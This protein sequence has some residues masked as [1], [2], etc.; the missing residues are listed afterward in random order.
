MK[1]KHT[2]KAAFP[3]KFISVFAKKFKMHNG[4]YECTFGYEAGKTAGLSA[5]GAFGS[6]EAG[7]KPGLLELPVLSARGAHQTG[8]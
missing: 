6:Y 4:R 8:G 1:V 7:K 2:H 5:P 3:F